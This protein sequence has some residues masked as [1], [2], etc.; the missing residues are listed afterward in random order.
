M[1]AEYD[2]FTMKFRKN[3]YAAKLKATVTPVEIENDIL[4]AF[5]TK[6]ND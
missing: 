2:L 6:G 1:Q 3:S 5:R 4:E